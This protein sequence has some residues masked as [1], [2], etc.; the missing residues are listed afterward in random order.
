MF[1]LV[2]M[3]LFVSALNLEPYGL[4]LPISMSSCS[5]T[6]RQSPTLLSISSGLSGDSTDFS[7]KGRYSD[8][9]PQ[10]ELSVLSLGSLNPEC[11]LLFQLYGFEAGWRKEAVG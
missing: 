3:L 5:I 9:Q 1:G 11:D 8:T 6:D 2:L 10:A 7:H 4:S